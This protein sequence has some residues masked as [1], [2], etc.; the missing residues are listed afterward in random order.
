MNRVG[1]LGNLTRVAVMVVL[2]LSTT[3]TGIVQEDDERIVYMSDR[4][5][6]REIYT[7]DSDG[8]DIRRL[9]NNDAQDLQPTWAPDKSQIAFVSNR[10]G[11]FA[12]FVMNADGSGQR[13]VST[14]QFAY[15][16]YP[17]W[18]PD[19]RSIAY[20]SDKSGNF[21]IYISNTDGSSEQRLTSSEDD[22]TE[23][24]WSPDSRQIAYL[25]MVDGAFTMF[26][27][28][29]NGGGV[30]RLTRGGDE[31][32]EYFSPRWS[33][34]G[35][36]MA[37]AV[38]TFDSAGNLSE[39]Y[40][41]DMNTGGERLLTSREDSFIQGIAWSWDSL[42]LLYQLRETRGSWTINIIDTD[43]RE[44]RVLT[45]QDYNSE[46][47]TWFTPYSPGGGSS[48]IRGVVNVQ[49]GDRLYLYDPT[50]VPIWV[51]S[52]PNEGSSHSSY[53]LGTAVEVI[54]SI[55]QNG[56]IQVRV[57]ERQLSVSQGWV[58]S[59][60]LASQISGQSYCDNT[61]ISIVHVGAEVI[62]AGPDALRLRS[63]AGTGGG[64]RTIIAS[65][66]ANTRMRVIGGPQ[67]ASGY[68]WWQVEVLNNSRR[69]WVAEGDNAEYF[70][71]FP[72]A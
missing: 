32:A 35:T 11:N 66:R 38:T 49:V 68:T 61:P 18:S 47:P 64:Q 17:A 59:S 50:G 34:D 14:D 21:D 5:G 52:G 43:G 25:Q 31:S 24:S 20:A 46:T 10:E 67:C 53:Q 19:G 33:P 44:A 28:A 3:E 22:E 29:R 45:S 70:I 58:R 41:R 72:G 48:G 62:V 57:L 63:E 56:Y 12:I 71:F 37:Y 1:T 42:N 51:R 4:D 27:M 23:P 6:N 39:I 8:D 65:L 16:E 13:R 26:M 60:Q 36:Q 2:L 7:M 15:H 30:Q 40:L 69:G 54:N 55:P 9:T